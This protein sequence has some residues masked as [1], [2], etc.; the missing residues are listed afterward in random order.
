MNYSQISSKSVKMHLL[1]G[2]EKMKRSCFPLER[3]RKP[4]NVS[5]K[6][7]GKGKSTMKKK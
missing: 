7:Q 5:G 3:N 4:N 2:V 6:M 1:E